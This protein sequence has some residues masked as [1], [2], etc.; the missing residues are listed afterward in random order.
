MAGFRASR[1]RDESAMTV[2]AELEECRGQMRAQQ[3]QC[4]QSASLW[5]EGEVGVERKE[6]GGLWSMLGGGQFIQFQKCS[7]SAQESLA[8]L[9]YIIF[10]TFQKHQN[11]TTE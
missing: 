9:V 2:K 4:R 5:V 1:Y 11:N 6:E 10:Q 3:E 8:V 7:G